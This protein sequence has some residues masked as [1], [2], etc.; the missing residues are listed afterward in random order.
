MAKHWCIVDFTDR[1]RDRLIG[2]GQTVIICCTQYDDVLTVLCFGRGPGE[3][4]RRPNER[5]SREAS[6]CN[7]IR[8]SIC[9]APDE[10]AIRSAYRKGEIRFLSETLITKIH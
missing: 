5:Q 4:S 10:I 8:D 1:N 3:S 2:S 9:G 6:G 7:G